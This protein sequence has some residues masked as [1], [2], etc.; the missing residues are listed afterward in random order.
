MPSQLLWCYACI[1]ECKKKHGFRQN[2]SPSWSWSSLDCEAVLPKYMDEKIDSF[3]CAESRPFDNP[4]DLDVVTHVKILKVNVNLSGHDVT[5]AVEGGR[6]GLTEPLFPMYGSA[7]FDYSQGMEAPPKPGENWG[8]NWDW[9]DISKHEFEQVFARPPPVS[10]LKNYF[11][12]HQ[13]L[14]AL[15]SPELTNMCCMPVLSTGT[16]IWGGGNGFV[17]GLVLGF[18]GGTVGVYRRV[19]YFECSRETSDKHTKRKPDA[20]APLTNQWPS[21]LN[22]SPGEGFTIAIV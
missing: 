16:S 8:I 20:T 21:R 6:I 5:G 13:R 19:G 2:H 17:Y 1:I 18:A 10:S 15:H 22:Y 11:R 3:P 9:D 7:A 4:I 12:N 14:L